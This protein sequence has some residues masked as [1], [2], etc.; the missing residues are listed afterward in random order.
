MGTFLSQLVARL[1]EEGRLTVEQLPVRTG[2][3]RYLVAQA[4]EHANGRR[5]DS[6]VETEGMYIESALTRADA[7]FHAAMLC[8]S[9]GVEVLDGGAFTDAAT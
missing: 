3:I 2:R 5:F 7:R 1:V 6:P 8:H 9:V 4:P